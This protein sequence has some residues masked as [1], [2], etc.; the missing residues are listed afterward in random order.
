MSI[1][2]QSRSRPYTLET[3]S[4]LFLRGFWYKNTLKMYVK[5]RYH[6]VSW[7]IG[8]YTFQ[9]NLEFCLWIVGPFIFVSSSCI[10]LIGVFHN[11]DTLQY[12]EGFHEGLAFLMLQQW[13][14]LVWRFGARMH[15]SPPVACAAVRSR[16]VV[17]LLLTYCLLLLPL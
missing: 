1:G 2:K 15:L 9:W 17:L 12:L 14:N 11:D 13:Q 6:A 7:Q 5:I 4:I 8:I 3:G 16:V 10:N